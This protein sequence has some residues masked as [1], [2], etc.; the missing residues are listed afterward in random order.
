[1][2][3]IYTGIS[4][5]L[6]A[7]LFAVYRLHD[8]GVAP[9]N[10][11]QAVAKGGVAKKAEP[12]S[13]ISTEKKQEAAPSAMEKKPVA[14]AA[15][16]LQKLMDDFPYLKERIGGILSQNPP[17]VQKAMGDF[18][19]HV[20][21]EIM[22][23]PALSKEDKNKILWNAFINAP[24]PFGR[25]NGL[26]G[27][28]SDLLL[29]N[30][31]FE[32]ANELRATYQKLATDSDNSTVLHSL[33]QFAD[34]IMKTDASSVPK[35]SLGQLNDSL[36]TTKALLLE[37]IK[38][39]ITSSKVEDLS[40]NAVSIYY[41]NT[42][43]NEAA[44]L[45]STIHSTAALNPD[46]AS[47]LY[48]AVW[49]NILSSSGDYNHP[50][51]SYPLSNLMLAPGVPA[52]NTSLVFVL[53]RRGG[54]DIASMPETTRALLLSHLQSVQRQSPDMP[55]LEATIAMLKAGQ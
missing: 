48:G 44:A 28:L 55:D 29:G 39:P 36:A 2:K 5:A 20:K 46:R 42:T 34:S 12:I 47:P 30:S 13:P 51:D 23:N 38:T 37:Q 33:L 19:D 53:L 43:Q 4:I 8:K 45:V 32:I 22:N 15:A 18:R 7:L 27:I 6:A 49:G 40:F 35:Q 25:E 24:R 54:I 17:E 26:L 11:A 21:R 16:K 41:R 10:N 50:I 52:V 3:K 9:K 31:P 14:D 1:M